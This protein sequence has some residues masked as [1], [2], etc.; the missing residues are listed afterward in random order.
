MAKS[1]VAILGRPN[2]G[3][4][5]LFN[6]LVGRRK[7]IVEATAG[8]TRDRIYG[9]VDWT[10]HS[11]HIIDTG[12][13]VASAGDVI[14]HTVQRQ[15]ALAGDEADLILFLVDSQEGIVSDDRDLAAR[16]RKL[17]KPVV[18]VVNKIDDP[19]HESRCLEFHEL[20]LGEPVAIG[21]SSGR[22]VGDLLDIVL[23]RLQ[24]GRDTGETSSDTLDLAIVGVPNV[25][26]SSFLNA[27]TKQEKAIV[28]PIPG[29]T[30]DSV[31]SYLQYM[32]HAIRLIDTAGLRRKARVSD[33]IEFYSTVRTYRSI[34]ECHVA[35]VMID[36]VRG[37]HDQ[38]RQIMAHVIEK[39]KGLV[40]VVN[41]WDAVEK[42]TAS[43]GQWVA[44]MRDQ[45]K[46][47]EHIPLVFTSVSHNQRLWHVLQQAIE[48]YQ[49]SIRKLSTS[50]LNKFLETA[51]GYLPPPAVQG[52]RIQIKYVTQVHR[53]PP[54]IAFFCNHPR[55]IP[56]SYQRFL[57]N[58]LREQFGF[59]GVP[60]KL[61]FRRK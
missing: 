29:T 43:M 36:A 11:F 53:Q 20:G 38:D 33:A 35:I 16:L 26:K 46:P 5:T 27:I 23:E 17:D 8:V 18:L 9:T 22:A 37:F 12:G 47:L 52:K 24:M 3:K 2:V 55:L 44:E 4:S 54:L 21:A 14:E 34:N 19:V 1:T 48:V 45:F 41:K 39:G 59:G 60:L 7:A 50:E 13:Y 30:R 42:D 56:V 32:G 61:S 49:Q 6:R 57:E 31:D 28:T 15:A 58:R 51:V 40:A 10:G 25:G